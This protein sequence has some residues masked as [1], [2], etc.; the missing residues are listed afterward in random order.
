MSQ[1]YPWLWIAFA[2]I[3][4]AAEIFTVGFVL[5]CFGIGAAA[6]AA[7]A[8]LGAGPAWQLAVFG[9]VSILAVFLSRPFANRISNPNTQQVGIDRVL[10]R[11]GVVLE[12]IDPN[13][14]TGVVRVRTETWSAI[15]TDGK[16]I[17]AGEHIVVMAVEGAHLVVRRDDAGDAA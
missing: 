12:T 14:G 5:F 7:V 10:G 3:F 4:F 16:P 8:F 17:Q 9:F 15:A 6:A 1:Y 13:A 2:L 11:N